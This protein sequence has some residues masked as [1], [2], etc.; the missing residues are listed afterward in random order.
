MNTRRLAR[1]QGRCASPVFHVRKL[2]VLLSALTASTPLLVPSAALAQ[3]AAS[4][5]TGSIRGRVLNATNGMY[6]GNAR[7]TVDG[8]N[9]ETF[10]N[11]FGEYT[12]NNVPAGSATLRVTYT[13]Q[14]PQVSTVV[15]SSSAAATQNITFKADQASVNEDGTLLLNEFTVAANRFRNA[16]ELAVNEQ[17]AA[18]NIK[19]VVSVDQ[20]GDIPSGNVGELVKFLPGVQLDYGS[21][22]GNNQ[23]YSDNEASGISVRGFGPEDTAILIDGM[24][25]SNATPGNLTRQVAL[26]QLS[27]NNASRVELIKVPTP[28]MPSNSVGGQINLITKSAFEQA[29]ASYSGRVFFNINSLNASLKKTAGPVKDKT[30]KTAPGIEAS[31]TIPFSNKFGVSFT[32]SAYNDA[33]Q[34]YRAVP[35]WGTGGAA[36]NA[37][38]SVSLSNPILNRYSA[39]DTSSYVEHRSSN[40]RFDWKP[41]TGQLLRAN[42]QYSTYDSA[43]AQ[44]RMDFRPNVGAGADFDA[45]HTTG[46]TANSTADMTVFTRDKEGETRSGQVQ[47]QLKKGGWIVDLA[48]STSISTGEYNDRD[49]GHFSE[50]ALKLNPGQVIFN[51][52]TDGGLV[53]SITT[54]NRTSNGGGVRDYSQLSNYSFD[55][56]IAKSGEA[57]TKVTKNLVKADVERD[58]SFIPFLGNNTLSVKTGY[59]YDS[60]KNVKSGLGTGYSQILRPGASYAVADILDTY[61]LD[62]KLGFGL[63]PQQWG[64][65]YRLFEINEANNLFYAPDG[66]DSTNNQVNNY[67]SW[68]NQQKSIK[69]SKEAWYAQLS[70]RFFS[71]RLSVVGGLRQE[72]TEREGYAPFTDSKWNYL[73]RA[74]GT[75]WSSS[76]YASGVQIDQGNGTID[77]NGNWVAPTSG[78][79]NRPIFDSSAAGI[80]LRA[81]LATEGIAVPN[82]LGPSGSSLASR[83]LQLQPNRYTHSKLTGDPSFSLNTSFKL[84]EKIDLKAAWS[85]TFSLPKL[86]DG[87][88]GLVSGT[89]NYSVTDYTPTEILNNNGYSGVI[90]VANPYL[91]PSVSDNLDFQIAYYLDSGGQISVSYWRKSVTNAPMKFNTDQGTPEF[92]ELL[93]AMGFSPEIYQNYYISTA[94]NSESKQETSGWEFEVRHDFSFLG[95]IGRNF[96]AFASFALNELGDPETPRVVQTVSPSGAI[97]TQ[98]PPAPTITKRS[99]RSGGAGLQYSGKRLTAQIR[100]VYRNENEIKRTAIGTTG[101]Y[102]RNFEPEETRIDISV[103]YVINQHFSLF[104]S[105]RDVFNASRKV[106]V[107]D[108][109]GLY[110]SYADLFDYREFGV[111]W[112]TGVNAKF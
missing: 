92:N 69:E 76:T 106:I 77:A 12:L 15:V 73:R 109:F 55:G 62:Q 45:T 108:D 39:Y 63:G 105:G 67:N 99:T 43:E 54:M 28:D 34:T 88:N 4:A 35:V 14:T 79:S 3:P 32:A 53:N 49:N 9:L 2:A 41:T 44:R 31:I 80:A 50:I 103:N 60:E 95:R 26:D 37:N 87:T 30:Y 38:G 66:P 71:N 20:F 112:S 70:G 61:Y 22:G 23:G 11:Q 110:P 84:T 33:N 75:I 29:H 90:S 78:T 102:M 89:N 93:T 46:T 6:L 19:N 27:I 85:R 94:T 42:V 101:N 48:G 72:R 81:Q 52:I 104:L 82:P 65:T 51:S 10:T 5:A 25:V 74:D 98:T 21:F 13:G 47:Y 97:I 40:L 91:L 86:E 68:V 24:P 7:V 83:M 8:T 100:G 16:Q 17:R 56:T 96:G 111:V 36:S 57:K 18:T 107:K 59:R 1:S 58:L 64:S